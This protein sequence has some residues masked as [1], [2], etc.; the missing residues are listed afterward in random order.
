MRQPSERSR[1]VV[2]YTL[3]AIETKVNSVAFRYPQFFLKPK[4]REGQGYEDVAKAAIEC[5]WRKAGIQ[6]EMRRAW[7]DKEIYGLG[8]VYTGWLFTTETG[9]RM[10][11]GRPPIWEEQMMMPDQTPNPTD[12]WQPE[13]QQVVRDDRFLAKRINPRHF[14][15]SPEAGPD[16][17]CA[18]FCGYC[19]VR[20][21]EEVKAD[22]RLKN[23][24]QLKG[25]M[26]NLQ[27]FF[28]KDMVKE[29][30]EN[31]PDEPDKAPDDVKRVKL[32]HYYEKKRRIHVVMCDEHEKPLLV[33]KW[34][35][36][37]DRYPFR[38]KQNPTDNDCFWG[39]PSPLLIE[40]QQRELNEARSQLSDHRRRFLPK[41]Q[42]PQGIL[43]SKAKNAL[44]SADAGEVVEHTS[45]EPAPVHPIE[46]PTIQP[47]VYATE[48]M[49]STDI[50]TVLA[51]NP[52]Q[53]GR[54]P[55]KRTP[56]AEVEAIQSQGAPRAE[57]DRQMFEEW[58]AE[59]A[60]DC[61]AWLKMYS[62]RT[63]QLPIYDT[64]G[65]VQSFIDFTREQIAGEYDIEVYVGSTTPPNDAARLEAIGFFL[66][67]L[68]PLI[69]LAMPAAQIGMNLVPLIRQLLKS[70]PDIRNID[71]ILP[72]PP[73]QAAPGVDPILMAGGAMGGEDPMAAGAM[74]MGPADGGFPFPPVDERTMPQL[75]LISLL[76]GAI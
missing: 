65:N 67:S 25:S 76:Q 34:T 43:S 74:G 54:A 26:T 63:R 60:E 66:Q 13:T 17:E 11:S 14:F 24:R 7:K 4:T 23:T 8:V 58:C 1:V 20:P 69:Q 30:I 37:H 28:D 64:D 72:M 48:Q 5:E 56:T 50:Q 71:E 18:E 52:Y 36:E 40:H 38:V 55:S 53:M 41:F 10:E 12:N 35:W 57:N 15:V 19:E 44:K 62:V 39:I 46:M 21:L 29:Y 59:I 61:L 51:I 45:S 70:L 31:D 9:K 27:A 22:S 33:E 49:V 42:A 6:S 47:E 3:N 32:Y 16:L 2:N 68:N 73:P 75:D